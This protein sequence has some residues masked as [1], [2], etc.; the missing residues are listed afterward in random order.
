MDDSA[1]G[2]AGTEAVL[3]GL[4]DND[5]A[6]LRSVIDEKELEKCIDAVS[7]AYKSP[8][9]MLAITEVYLGNTVKQVRAC[10]DAI[11]VQEETTRMQN[12]LADMYNPEVFARLI[13]ETKEKYLS[14][15]E[16]T[17]RDMN[18]VSEL[19]AA[20]GISRRVAPEQ[21]VEAAKQTT[22]THTKEI[23]LEDRVHALSDVNR[24]TL[25]T[26]LGTFIG[27]NLNSDVVEMLQG[28]EGEGMDMDGK[29]ELLMSNHAAVLRNP[30]IAADYIGK[31]LM[32]QV[33]SG[34]L[35][36]ELSLRGLD[37]KT[38]SSM[39]YSYRNTSNNPEVLEA[40]IIA[41]LSQLTSA[42]LEAV[43][44]QTLH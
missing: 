19:L 33:L 32:D 8:E 30:D 18:A 17:V 36:R 6:V 42:A 44:C 21:T 40:F 29:K 13:E 11:R 38:I 15:D 9:I 39:V 22:R 31:V 7:A 37:D 41:Y 5:C 4:L 26:S 35:D 23:S 2:L 28:M 3:A 16:K 43:E 12:A 20:S 34:S 10:V 1:A 14:G 27:L 25:Q 24:E